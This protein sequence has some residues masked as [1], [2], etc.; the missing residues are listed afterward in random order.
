[1]YLWELY[2]LKNTIELEA[3]Q[4]EKWWEHY[5]VSMWV[6]ICITIPWWACTIRARL[7]ALNNW[8]SRNETRLRGLNNYGCRNGVRVRA[9]HRWGCRKGVELHKWGAARLVGLLDW[10]GWVGP[11]HKHILILIRVICIGT[12]F[13][14]FSIIM[15]LDINF[16]RS[17]AL[18]T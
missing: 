3:K 16:F 1:M 9:M 18:K 5:K 2:S 15:C 10:W 8:G 11:T 12:I 7:R 13:M 17:W 6:V 4:N 14:K